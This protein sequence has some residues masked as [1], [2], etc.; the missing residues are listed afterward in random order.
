MFN[1]IKF[2]EFIKRMVAA[3]SEATVL[4]HAIIVGFFVVGMVPLVMLITRLLSL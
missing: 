4:D 3:N 2:K 1:L